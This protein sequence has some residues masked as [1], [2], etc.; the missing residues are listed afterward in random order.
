M[1]YLIDQYGQDDCLYSQNPKAR[2]VINQRLYFDMDLLRSIFATYV[3]IRSIILKWNIWS[4]HY[5]LH[6]TYII[7]I[8]SL[9]T[10]FQEP[11]LK[12]LSDT[13]D[14]VDYEK[15]IVA[16]QFLD[17]F[18]EGQDYVAG[19]DFTIADI[20]MVSSVTAAE[21]ISMMLCEMKN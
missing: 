11:V 21:V 14:P 5:M 17:K 12:K 10:L 19:N 3:R 1:C 7:Y 8:M 2:A 20:A 4:D 9:Y 15:M 13:I 18:L 16:F 6:I